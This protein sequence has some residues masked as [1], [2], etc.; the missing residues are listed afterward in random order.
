MKELLKF[1][2]SGQN[3]PM[4]VMVIAFLIT[5]LKV[6]SGAFIQILS[7]ALI[8]GLA[9]YFFY[10]PDGFLYGACLGLLIGVGCLFAGDQ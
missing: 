6:L 2:F 10:G 7:M 8:Y 4:L 3:I 9:A 5:T 1:L